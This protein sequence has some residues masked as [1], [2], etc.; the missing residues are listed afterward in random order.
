ME[1]GA[2]VKAA[3]KDLAPAKVEYGAVGKDLALD[4]AAV[5]DLDKVKTAAKD[6]A[7]DKA[8]VGVLDKV[9]AAP[10]DQALDKVAAV[11]L[12]MVKVEAKEWL[13]T[14]RRLG[15]YEY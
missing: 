9:K 5:G 3:A 14:R 4:K 12:D 7:P 1:A 6:L 13:W 15:L 11:A 2:L 8:A 10:K